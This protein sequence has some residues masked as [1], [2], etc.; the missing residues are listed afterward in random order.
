M[1][2]VPPHPSAFLHGE[3][4]AAA[5]Q[6]KAVTTML[7]LLSMQKVAHEVP[8]R[9]VDEINQGMDEKNERIVFDHIVDSSCHSG[10]NQVRLPRRPGLAPATLRPAPAC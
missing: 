4:T 3:L 7:Y 8:F 6:E 2:H 1:R 10:D 9:V 5:P